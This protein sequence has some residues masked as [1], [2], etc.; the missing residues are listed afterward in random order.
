M[1]HTWL[2]TSRSSRPAHDRRNGP[3]H[4]PHPGVGDAEP[5]EWSVAAGVEEDVECAQE[6]RERVNRQREQSDSWDATGQSEAD[7]VEGADGREKP[8]ES[9]RKGKKCKFRR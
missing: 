2:Q 1:I 4:G 5:L 3:H 9:E 6:A 7:G 8:V